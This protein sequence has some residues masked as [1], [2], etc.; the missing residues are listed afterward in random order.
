MSEELVLRLMP[1]HPN[2]QQNEAYSYATEGSGANAEFCCSGARAR[3]AKRRVCLHRPEDD[4]GRACVTK[5]EVTEV[6][7]DGP[8]SQNRQLSVL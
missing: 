4:R 6:T 7:G 1:L 5:P 3:S 2:A 8:V